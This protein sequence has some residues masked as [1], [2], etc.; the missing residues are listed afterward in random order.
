MTTTA[1][2]KQLAR[3]GEQHYRRKEFEAA[4]ISFGQAA[5]GYR[6]NDQPQLAAEMANN[7]CVAWVQLDR[8]QLAYEAV[9][10]T[11][12]LLEGAGDHEKAARAFGNLG[13]ALEGLGRLAEAESAYQRAVALFSEAGSSEERAHTYKALSRLRMRQGQPLDAVSTMQLGLQDS[14]SRSVS[15]RLLGWLLQLPSRFLRG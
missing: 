8:Y 2:A 9:R 13:S 11:P 4:A 5:E 15:E 12:E 3:E 7:E 10:G 14:Q 6:D 1:D